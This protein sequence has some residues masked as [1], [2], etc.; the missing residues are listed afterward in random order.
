MQPAFSMN[1]PSRARTGQP[2]EAKNV[3][4][5]FLSSHNAKT[6]LLWKKYKETEIFLELVASPI[7]KKMLC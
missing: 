7:A 4:R 2:L 6:C 3:K 1:W 5:T